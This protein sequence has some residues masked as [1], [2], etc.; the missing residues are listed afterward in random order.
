MYRLSP[1]DKALFLEAAE[2]QSMELSVWVR[3]TLRKAAQREL[4]EA[5]RK[6]QPAKRKRSS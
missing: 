3:L 4:E 1:E 2:L 6:P 5:G